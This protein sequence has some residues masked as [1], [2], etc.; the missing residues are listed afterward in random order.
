[1]D[2]I[3]WEYRELGKVPFLIKHAVKVEAPLNFVSNLLAI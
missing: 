1:M 3:S 2:A